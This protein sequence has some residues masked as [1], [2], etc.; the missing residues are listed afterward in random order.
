MDGGVGE[1]EVRARGEGRVSTIEQVENVRGGT[2]G[3][4]GSAHIC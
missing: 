1:A 2:N 3:M 4:T